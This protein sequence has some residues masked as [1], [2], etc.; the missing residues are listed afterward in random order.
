MKLNNIPKIKEVRFIKSRKEIKEIPLSQSQINNLYDSSLYQIC[1]R[2][3]HELFE[4]DTVN[5]LDIIT[6]N[7]FVKFINKTNGKQADPTG[8]Q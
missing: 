3:I 5:G 1:L 7:G 4:A 6:F 8:L 2:T